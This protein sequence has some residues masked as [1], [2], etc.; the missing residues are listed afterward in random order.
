MNSHC[1]RCDEPITFTDLHSVSEQHRR[2]A[3]PSGD[4]GTQWCCPDASP[5][6]CA[7]TVLICVA[8]PPSHMLESYVDVTQPATIAV[9]A[10]K[11]GLSGLTQILDLATTHS[12]IDHPICA[13]CLENVKREL[14]DNITTTEAQASAYEAALKSLLVSIPTCASTTIMH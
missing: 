14:Q 11:G 7:V 12:Q 3:V 1:Q 8:G 2:H 4:A 10:A 5:N 13:K 9:P 6:G